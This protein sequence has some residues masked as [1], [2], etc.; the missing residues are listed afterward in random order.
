MKYKK[1]PLVD[2]GRFLIG[3]TLVLDHRFYDNFCRIKEEE[4]IIVSG[5]INPHFA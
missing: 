2:N 3:E 5:H 1:R 4:R